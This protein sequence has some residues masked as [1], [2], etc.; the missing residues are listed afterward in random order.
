LYELQRIGA[1]IHLRG[2]KPHAS[3]NLLSRLR[4]ADLL[5]D[6]AKVR[7][8]L[9]LSGQKLVDDIDFWDQL[10]GFEPEAIGGEMEGAGLYVGF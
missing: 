3:T 8:D 10:R 2:D 1:E 4:N 5:W 6:G 9:V 7:F